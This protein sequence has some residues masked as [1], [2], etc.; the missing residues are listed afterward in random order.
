MKEEEESSRP[1]LTP[2][3]VTFLFRQAER[4]EYGIVPDSCLL[5]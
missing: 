4:Q 2:K 5:V 3:S 1:E